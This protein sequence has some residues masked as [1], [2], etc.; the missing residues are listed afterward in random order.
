MAHRHEYLFGNANIPEHV[1]EIVIDSGIGRAEWDHITRQMDNVYGKT[2]AK[3]IMRRMM[4]GFGISAMGATAI[5]NAY[6]AKP[7]T[8]RTAGIGHKKQKVKEPERL[9]YTQPKA[10]ESEKVGEKRPAPPVID[11]LPTNP[12]VAKKTDFTPKKGFL[13]W[14]EDD[15]QQRDHDWLWGGEDVDMDEEPGLGD[16]IPENTGSGTSET[17]SGSGMDEPMEPGPAESRM[18]AAGGSNQVSKETP[19]S[20]YPSLSY[21]LPETHTTI[22]PWTGWVSAAYLDKSTPL[23]LKIRMNSPYDMLDMGT[24]AAIGDGAYP[25]TKGF[26][27]RPI[28]PQGRISTSGTI[29]NY[30]AVFGDAETTAAE[31]PQW[32]EYWAALYDYYTVLGCEYEIILYNPVQLKAYNNNYIRNKTIGGTPFNATYFRDEAGNFN[33]DV[34]VA[35][36]FDTYSAT[37]TTTGNVMPKT[38]YAEMRAFKNIRWTPVPGGRKAIIRGK[39]HPGMAKRNIVNDGDVKTW[40]KVTDG[41]PNT[42]SEI[43]TLNFFADPFN[44]ARKPDGYGNAGDVEP[45]STGARIGGAVNMEINLKYIVQYKDLR[46]QA[47]YPNSI[48]NNQDITQILGDAITDKGSALMSWNTASTAQLP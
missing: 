14:Y 2:G 11:K 15:L 9:T 31:R 13:E 22:L 19:I 37:A 12:K 24:E 43:L 35:T 42:L 44:N 16:L 36:Q 7:W 3:N 40:T 5:W 4:K 30:P 38:N 41:I 17:G 47:R 32:R 21:G 26:Y 29:G 6:K 46:L 18:A 23:Q 8:E 20:S 34:V 39:Y 33:T 10:I 25:T 28:D 45:N 27:A 1:V 48:T